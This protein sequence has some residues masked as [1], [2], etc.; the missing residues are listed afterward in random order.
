MQQAAHHTALT[1]GD[2]T[3]FRIF[4]ED[5]NNA[6]AFIMRKSE[7][8]ARCEFMDLKIEASYGDPLEKSKCA[9]DSEHLF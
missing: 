1:T 4:I 3:E 6:A 9:K 2:F 7:D 5:T 8:Q